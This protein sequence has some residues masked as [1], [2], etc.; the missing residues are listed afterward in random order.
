MS[1]VYILDL[2]GTLVF[3]ISGVTA[4]V[5]KKFDLVGATILGMVTAIGGGTLRDLLIGETPVS[6]MK[7]LN[8]L[9]VI[10]AALPLCYFFQNQILKLRRGVFLFDTIGIGLFTI[11]GV[12]KTLALGLSPLIALLM[13]VVSAVFGGVI[14]DILSNEVPLIFRKEIYASACLIGGLIFLGMHSLMPG[15]WYNSLAAIAVVILIRYLAVRN[16]WGL[17]FRPKGL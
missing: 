15:S 4:A 9:Y 17:P 14:R 2:I 12:Q 5:E 7:D 16:N 3:A 13:G 10:I 8:Y 1:F 11:L 6:W